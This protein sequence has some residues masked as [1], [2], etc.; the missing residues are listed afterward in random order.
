[1]ALVMPTIGAGKR[2]PVGVVSALPLDGA[3][4]RSMSPS[5]ED[6][7]VTLDPNGKTS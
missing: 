2:C 4:Q 7:S 6:S 3:K 1:M 5:W